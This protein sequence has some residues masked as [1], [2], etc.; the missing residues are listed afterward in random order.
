ML[1]Q[2]RH[3]RVLVPVERPL[4]LPDHDRVPPAARIGQRRHQ[5]GGLCPP[6]PRQRPALPRI[7]E[8]GHDHPVPADQHDSL[9]QLPCP[10]RHRVLP[11]FGRHPAVERKP[12]ASPAAHPC[13]AANALR[14]LRQHISS[15]AARTGSA[16]ARPRGRLPP[17]R[18][19]TRHQHASRLP[20]PYPGKHQLDA[21]PGSRSALR[22]DR[23]ISPTLTPTSVCRAPW[24][25]RARG[26]S[27]C[28]TVR[29]T[30]S[31]RSSGT[32][33]RSCTATRPGSQT[34]DAGGAR[35]W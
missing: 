32:Q 24:R 31:T 35:A 12:Q 22:A 21:P 25:R 27:R 13:P 5:D 2:R 20:L 16:I 15:A 33:R 19:R 23:R 4:V 34:G 6:R 3:Q 7:E 10:R 8:L 28:S 17:W 1:E 30:R 18:H 26:P 11:V 29:A 14:P 9:L